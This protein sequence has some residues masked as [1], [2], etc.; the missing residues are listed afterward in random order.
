MMRDS[1]RIVFIEMM[2]EP[3]SFDASVYDHFEDKENEGQWF[4]KRFQH[5]NGFSISCRNICIGE[6]LPDTCEF[7]GLVLAGSYNSVHDNTFWQQRIRS[8]LPEVRQHKKPILAVCGSHQ[9]IAH[10]AGAQVKRL[11]QGP[12][13]GTFAVQLTEAGRHSPLFKGIADDGEFN[14]ANGEHVIE[15]PFGATLLGSSSRVPV[16]ALDYGN[17]CYTT[18]FHPEGSNETLGT[19]W[20]FKAPELM[21]NYHPHDLGDLL[22]SNFFNIVSD[23]TSRHQ[24]SLGS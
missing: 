7:D 20:R 17:H 18:Q 3:G 22:V 23:H 6:S 5:L 13:A 16:A 4:I 2:G 11:E 10:G 19:V 9:L 24:D 8:W 14:Y 15:V 1:I 21:K 12:F